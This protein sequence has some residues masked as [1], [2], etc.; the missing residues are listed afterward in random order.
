MRIDQPHLSEKVTD[1]SRGIE[2]LKEEIAQH[3]KAV[4]EL[5]KCVKLI[6]GFID[7]YDIVDGQII[8]KIEALKNK[9]QQST[10][11]FEKFQTDIDMN[12]LTDSKDN[13]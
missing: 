2:I 1:H 11:L 10:E 9:I 7:Q 4:Q 12:E 3:K 13:A 6:E 8:L 5:S